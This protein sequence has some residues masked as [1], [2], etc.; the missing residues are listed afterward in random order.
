MTSVEFKSN[1]M[2]LRNQFHGEGQLDIPKIKRQDIDIE[3]ISLIGYNQISPSIEK[4]ND[5]VH[6]FIDDYRFESIWNDPEPRISKLN[7]CKGVLAPQFSTYYTMPQA[8]QIFNTFRSRW[9][10]AYFQSKGLKVIPTVS[11][12][13]PESYWYC[14]DGIEKGSI[15]A[16]STLGVKKEKDFFMQGYK[17]MI[18][19]IEPEAIICYSTPFEEM[20][21]NVIA[22]DYAETNNLSSKY[23]SFNDYTFHSTSDYIARGMGGAGIG[24]PKFPGWDSSVSP[25]KD[26]EWRGKGEPS[27]GRGSWVNPK[28]KEVLHPDL[29]HSGTIGPHWDYTYPGSGNGFRLFPDGTL[30]PKF[31]E[32]DVIYA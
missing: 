27:S 23:F 30:V 24:S 20:T 31:Y 8:L 13:T 7:K 5:Y 15:V 22:I 2:F 10:G 3:N 4:Y 14:F 1:P 19:R 17:E 6:F 21:G 25:G 29:N 12:G 11:W 26:Y 16:I 18:K 28:T 9:C 32:G